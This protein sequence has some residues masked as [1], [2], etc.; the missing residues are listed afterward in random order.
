M[1]VT[2]AEAYNHLKTK[3]RRF[4]EA[5]LEPS[6]DAARKLIWEL[7]DVV[8][9]VNT[10]SGPTL[11]G[12]K[13]KAIDSLF[14]AGLLVRKCRTCRCEILMCKCGAKRRRTYLVINRDMLR[15]LGSI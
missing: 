2:R 1:S 3:I 8:D 6:D 12:I 5:S 10:D 13:A 9:Q 7:N 11:V 15:R 14:E 4:C